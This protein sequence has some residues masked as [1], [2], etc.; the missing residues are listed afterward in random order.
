MGLAKKYADDLMALYF[1]ARSKWFID[2]YK[3]IEDYH[4]DLLTDWSFGIA[5]HV[6]EGSFFNFPRFLAT[7]FEQNDFSSIML[8]SPSAHPMETLAPP[9]VVIAFEEGLAEIKKVEAA[10]VALAIADEA[11]TKATKELNID[12]ERLEKNTNEL[13]IFLN[14]NQ[15]EIKRKLLAAKKENMSL[16]QCL[17]IHVRYQNSPVVDST[18]PWPYNIGVSRWLPP[19]YPDYLNCFP[20]YGPSPLDEDREEL[21]SVSAE[22]Y[23]AYVD[24][25]NEYHQIKQYLDKK[26]M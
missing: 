2:P 16:K 4:H 7:K 26:I 12:R 10:S 18:L 6:C 3:S 20:S 1:Y 11:H 15:D 5:A 14:A 17:Q 25:Y 19:E 13:S 21:I 23:R 8:Y 22:I 9:E 24:C